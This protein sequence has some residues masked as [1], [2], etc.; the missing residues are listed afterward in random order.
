MSF[1]EDD[2]ADLQVRESEPASRVCE[3]TERKK[4]SLYGVL[5]SATFPAPTGPG[6]FSATLF[7]GT[8]SI[9]VV[10]LGRKSV[11][12]IKAGIRLA[13]QGMVVSRSNG[14]CIINPTFQIEPVYADGQ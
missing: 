2:L 12:G 9:D 14:L 13:V 5:R 8:G 10:W 6:S 4:A 1:P 7:D 3:V 11:P